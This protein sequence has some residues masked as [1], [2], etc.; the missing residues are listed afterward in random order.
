VEPE[1]SGLG[2]PISEVLGDALDAG[3]T[4]LQTAF[5]RVT[6]AQV[7][8]GVGMNRNCASSLCA[9]NNAAMSIL[10]GCEDIQIAGGVEHIRNCVLGAEHAAGEIGFVSGNGVARIQG[11]L[12]IVEA[13]ATADFV[14]ARFGE[15]FDASKAQP[16]VFGRE[17]ILIDPNL[18]N[19]CF[20]REAASETVLE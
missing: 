10:S 11:A 7:R 5:S 20:G 1:L 12:A 8:V 6:S 9:L 15:D 17:R 3:F 19:G 4:A 2:G 16:V 18:A 14:A 13:Q